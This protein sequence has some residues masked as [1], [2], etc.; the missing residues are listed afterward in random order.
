VF[1]KKKQRQIGLTLAEI[2][3]AIGVASISII[4]VALVLATIWR[5]ASEG[6]YQA[7]ASNIARS[8]I[9]KMRGDDHFFEFV[10][11]NAG[12]TVAKEVLK[13][14][15][16]IETEFETTI[17][18]TPLSAGSGY[19]DVVVMVAWDQEHRKRSVK[20]ET[21]LPDPR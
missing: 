8:R 19:F 2:L 6:K 20:L 12:S 21:V 15:D 9:E 11:Q 1:L 5:A 13:V 14:D 17:T 4:G 18:T 3:L 16:K 10:L 7:A